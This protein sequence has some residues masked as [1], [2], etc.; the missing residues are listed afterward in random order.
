MPTRARALGPIGEYLFHRNAQ[1]LGEGLAESVEFETAANHSGQVGGL[2]PE[3]GSSL[4]HGEITLDQAHTNELCVGHCY[5]IRQCVPAG[6]GVFAR[7][8]RFL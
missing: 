1:Q 8:Y 2:Q 6:F 7:V 5:G 4:V 3:L